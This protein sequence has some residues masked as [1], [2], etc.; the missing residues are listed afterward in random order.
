MSNK[1]YHLKYLKKISFY[2]SSIYVTI[3]TCYILFFV[4]KLKVEKYVQY[5]KI[6]SHI[7]T[8]NSENIIITKIK[9]YVEN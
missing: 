7:S 6:Q 2:A 8:Y 1:L 4:S 9:F 3:S 5:F